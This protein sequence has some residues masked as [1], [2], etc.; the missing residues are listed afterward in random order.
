LADI[1][2]VAI[3]KF[4]KSGNGFQKSGKLRHSIK[5]KAKKNVPSLFKEVNKKGKIIH[6]WYFSNDFT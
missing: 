2:R 6:I 3:K 1:Y 5:K 4:I